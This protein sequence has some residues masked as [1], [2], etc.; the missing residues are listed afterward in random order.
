[1]CRVV[2]QWCCSTLSFS[3]MAV[4]SSGEHFYLLPLVNQCS[5]N[6]ERQSQ[7]ALMMC[8]VTALVTALQQVHN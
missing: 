5:R 8:T 3:S 6:T 4:Q 2:I 1:M 7:F